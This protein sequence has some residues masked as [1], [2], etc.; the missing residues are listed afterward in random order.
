MNKKELKSWFKEKKIPYND[1]FVGLTEEEK[2]QAR[3][4]IYHV[5]R[6]GFDH[7]LFEYFCHHSSADILESKWFQLLQ[8]DLGFDVVRHDV[9]TPS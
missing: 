6:L 3:A 1:Y 2:G 7:G 9:P 5:S 4:L 8:Q